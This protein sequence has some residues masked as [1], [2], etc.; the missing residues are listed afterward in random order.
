[1]DQRFFFKSQGSRAIAVQ[2]SERASWHWQ[3]S[4][5]VQISRRSEWQHA[6]QG[7]HVGHLV[8][9][10]EPGPLQVGGVFNIERNAD[11]LTSLDQETHFS[12]VTSMS[13][14]TEVGR[15]VGFTVCQDYCISFFELRC[16][17]NMKHVNINGVNCRST[18]SDALGFFLTFFKVNP[19]KGYQVTSLWRTTST[20]TAVDYRK[21]RAH[22]EQR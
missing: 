22:V 10:H 15:A 4:S 12:P 9:G 13:S 17:R 11:C 2:G 14:F 8:S 18:P 21:V 5:I 19:C 3:R 20:C 1:M 7:R 16:T 6:N